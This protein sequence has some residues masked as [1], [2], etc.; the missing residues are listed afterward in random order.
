MPPRN[1][2]NRFKRNSNKPG[3]SELSTRPPPSVQWSAARQ[4]AER[5]LAL[6]RS[7]RPGTVEYE[8]SHPKVRV[9]SGDPK[10]V[11]IDS[12]SVIDDISDDWLRTR[13]NKALYSEQRNRGLVAKR[14][15]HSGG[16]PASNGDPNSGSR[17]ERSLGPT[18]RTT[19]RALQ[20]GGVTRLLSSVPGVYAN[21]PTTS[22]LDDQRLVHRPSGNVTRRSPDQESIEELYKYFNKIQEYLVTRTISIKQDG[23][24]R[25]I[26]FDGTGKYQ[27]RFSP[28]EY[29]EMKREYNGKAQEFNNRK[30][31]R[32]AIYSTRDPN[33]KPPKLFSLLRVNQETQ[34]IDSTQKVINL[35]RKQ[36]ER[37]Q[38]ESFG[39]E[40]PKLSKEEMR[41]QAMKG[42]DY[43]EDN[44]RVTDMDKHDARKK[45]YYTGISW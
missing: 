2:T 24:V 9:D 33:A 32:Y 12:L 17:S 38:I 7:E 43:A 3:S 44:R 8:R 41:H 39:Q 21:I 16:T 1:K 14:G 20:A 35:I 18:E 22:S 23:V 10:P 34:G 6:P 45:K 26:P 15:D 29:K 36:N 31:E 13:A 4:E 5:V 28:L 25:L 30:K 42:H 19:S 27:P 40:M 11:R 37:L